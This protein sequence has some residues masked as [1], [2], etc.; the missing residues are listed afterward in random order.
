MFDTLKII[1][2]LAMGLGVG[3][4]VVKAILGARA[5]AAGDVIAEEHRA[6]QQITGR[7][8]AWSL[9]AIWLTGLAMFYM[10][11]GADFG[12]L[13]WAFHV[14]LLFA[15]IFTALTLYALYVSARAR[16][17]GTRPD[18]A[19]MRTAGMAG[20]VALILTVIFAVVAF[21]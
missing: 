14:K 13:D 18:A 2:L 20:S 6:V 11:Y 4:A 8:G 7:I 1:H 12:A 10:R 15:L 21:G 16:A 3:F 19:M 5:R 9:L 17:S